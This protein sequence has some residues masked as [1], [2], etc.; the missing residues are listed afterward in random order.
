MVLPAAAT[1]SLASILDHHAVHRPDRLAVIAG[2]TRLTYAQLAAAAK[3]VK[4]KQ[5]RMGKRK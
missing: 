5:K 2:P 3:K 4:K 1:Y